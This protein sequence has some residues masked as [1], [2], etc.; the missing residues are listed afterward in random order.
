MNV[1]TVLITSSRPS[2][3]LNIFSTDL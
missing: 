3:I 2:D 1:L